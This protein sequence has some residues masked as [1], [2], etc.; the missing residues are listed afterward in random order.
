MRS[1]R[2][3]VSVT[4]EDAPR[5]PEAP[6]ERALPRARHDAP[7]TRLTGAGN[8]GVGL[9]PPQRLRPTWT[10]PFSPGPAP[11]P[12][13]PDDGDL[14]DGE[15]RP[16]RT[17]SRLPSCFR[18]LVLA[19]TG[20]MIAA[21]L[22]LFARA[23]R[24]EGARRGV[25]R[26]HRPR[27]R[28]AVEEIDAYDE[29][30]EKVLKAPTDEKDREYGGRRRRRSRR[31]AGCRC[32]RRRRSSR[33]ARRRRVREA[34]DDVPRLGAAAGG[35]GIITEG[36]W[37]SRRGPSSGDEGDHRQANWLSRGGRAGAPP[38]CR[39]YDALLEDWEAEAKARRR[40]T[41]CC[42]SSCASARRARVQLGGSAATSRARCRSASAPIPG[43]ARHRRLL[44]APGDHEEL[45]RAVSDPDDKDAEG[46]D[47]SVYKQFFPI[48][49]VVM[50]NMGKN[51]WKR[52]SVTAR[53]QGRGR[54]RARTGS[55]STR[56]A[57][58]CT[59]RTTPTRWCARRRPP[60]RRGRRRSA[61][62]GRP[63]AL[64]HGK[65]RGLAPGKIEV[66][67]KAT[68]RRAAGRSW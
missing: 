30:I 25:P 66:R 23:L 44:T 37:R 40:A 5:A 2:R 1:T 20:V 34:L 55:I 15:W 4:V 62:R 13:V 64:Q 24:G 11:P 65:E 45:I 51:G 63:R 38:S 35:G 31:R 9:R 58:R 52:G 33:S 6:R 42:R 53:R 12:L 68:R 61:S 28:A 48:G 17:S 7:K 3:S 10:T 21:A 8:S 27:R 29:Y 16:L 14:G 59:R 41:S 36:A 47:L 43:D 56:W 54:R 60:R 46:I 22:Y 19:T 67:V 18:I 49:T 32:A 26:R 39:A 57:A 50:A